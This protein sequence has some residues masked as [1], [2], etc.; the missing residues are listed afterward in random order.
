MPIPL[1]G[2]GIAEHDDKNKYG[3]KELIDSARRLHKEDVGG[4]L[5]PREVVVSRINE[6][7]KSN[8]DD[9]A[10][11][12]GLIHQLIQQASRTSIG[13]RKIT[14]SGLLRY[15]GLVTKYRK[16]GK[17]EKKL[18]VRIM[19]YARGIKGYSFDEFWREKELIKLIGV[20]EYI[21]K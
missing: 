3:I 5:E 16:T 8:T 9:S 17:H 1:F 7:H 10:V 15:Q 21:K 12:T 6:N 11:L 14:A 20:E 2:G 13:Q 18:K 4:V 19:M